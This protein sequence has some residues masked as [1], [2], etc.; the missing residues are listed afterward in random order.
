MA[1]RQNMREQRAGTVGI[2]VIGQSNTQCILRHKKTLQAFFSLFSHTLF[3][4]KM[5]VILRRKS[6]FFLFFIGLK[7]SSMQYGARIAFAT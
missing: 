5:Y 7:S 1:W 3:W 6:I 4:Y 2:I